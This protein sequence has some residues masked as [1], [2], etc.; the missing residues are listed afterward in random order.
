MELFRISQSH[1][2][3]F[4]KCICEVAGGEGEGVSVLPSFHWTA[5]SRPPALKDAG[6]RSL[7][8]L[9]GPGVRRGEKRREEVPL[10]GVDSQVF[11]LVQQRVLLHLGLGQR[12]LGSGQLHFQAFVLLLQQLQTTKWRRSGHREEPVSFDPRFADGLRRPIVP[13][14]KP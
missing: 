9:S 14:G 6:G 5:K 2:G 8:W 4:D 13:S 1:G 7:S 12:H 11:H 10:A 3:S